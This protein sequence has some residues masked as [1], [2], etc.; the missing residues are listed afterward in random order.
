MS[1]PDELKN[2]ASDERAASG[3]TCAPSSAASSPRLVTRGETHERDER[4]PASAALI[5]WLAFTVSTGPGRDR[6]WL[7]NALEVFFC[8]PRTGWTSTGRGW[9]GYSHRID[10]GEFGLLAFGGKSQKNTVHVE[11]NAHGCALVRDWNAV[12]LWGE[13]YDAV[14]TRVDLAHDDF[15]GESVSVALAR[16]WWEAGKFDSNG[17]PPRSELWDDLDL[18]YGK[19]LYVG[20][21]ASGKVLRVYEKGKQLGWRESPWVRAEVELRNKGRDVPWDVV[22]A[23]GHYLAGAYPALAFLSAEQCRL[24]TRAR[25][26]HIAY[27]VMVENLRTQGGKALNVMCV[28]NQGDAGAVLAQVIRPGVPKRLSGISDAVRVLLSSGHS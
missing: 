5:D 27:E 23:P 28:V 15:L 12:R 19:T 9:F 4:M 25:E 16:Q 3:A 6:A 18:G 26:G 1:S 20:R 14:I 10:L 17:R 21:R 2:A 11:L 22:K 8:V 24:R 7:E 13:T